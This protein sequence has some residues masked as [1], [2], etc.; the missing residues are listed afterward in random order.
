MYRKNIEIALMVLPLLFV[1][2]CES[3]SRETAKAGACVGKFRFVD[4]EVGETHW[5]EGQGFQAIGPIPGSGG[6]APELLINVPGGYDTKQDIYTAVSGGAS[7]Y[8]VAFLVENAL[9]P[10]ADDHTMDVEVHLDEDECPF[11]LKFMTDGPD[12]S[13]SGIGEDHGGHAGAARF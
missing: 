4:V 11:F 1:V 3:A 12:E 13:S 10:A 6:G 7:T 2:G 8:S 5:V 9:H